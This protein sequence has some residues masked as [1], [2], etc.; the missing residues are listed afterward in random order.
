V[1][2]F[3][4]L[5]DGHSEATVIPAVDFSSLKFVFIMERQFLNDSNKDIKP[6]EKP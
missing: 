5:I 1:K 4:V 3:R 2:E 6:G